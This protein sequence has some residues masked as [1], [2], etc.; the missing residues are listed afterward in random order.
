VCWQSLLT[1]KLLKA[2]AS[3]GRSRL[4]AGG[5]RSAIVNDCPSAGAARCGRQG[6]EDSRVKAAPCPMYPEVRRPCVAHPSAFATN[7]RRINARLPAARR[8]SNNSSKVSL[9]GPGA[10]RTRPPIRSRAATARARADPEKLLWRR[11]PALQPAPRLGPP[12]GM[13]ALPPKRRGQPGPPGPPVLGVQLRCPHLRRCPSGACKEWTMSRSTG[14]R[15]SRSLLCCGKRRP[16]TSW[17][18]RGFFSSLKIRRW[19]RRQR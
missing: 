5:R 14:L 7:P 11:W 15:H 16:A 1:A 4:R 6:K 8:K 3:R 10:D 17:P 19:Q 9:L 13:L 2:A 12:R 18:Q